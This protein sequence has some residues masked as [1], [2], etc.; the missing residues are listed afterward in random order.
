MSQKIEMRRAEFLEI[1]MSSESTFVH[2]AAYYSPLETLSPNVSFSKDQ[3]L[4]HVTIRKGKFA[5]NLNEVS[6][7]LRK[8]VGELAP[9]I[10]REFVCRLHHWNEGWWAAADEFMEAHLF[11]ID[12]IP[13]TD[14][15]APWLRR[16]ARQSED[17]AEFLRQ[18]TE[19]MHDHGTP[20]D[21]E[22]RFNHIGHMTKVGE[23]DQPGD[24]L[25]LAGLVVF[26][27]KAN[28]GQLLEQTPHVFININ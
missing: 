26:D 17:P 5:G 16:D 24:K 9:M 1:E 15:I 4:R 12:K 19:A 23:S 8:H 20:W 22:D 13:L 11:L 27:G 10:P 14:Y 7:L 28:K 6:A 2:V 3:G 21:G 18:C 25:A